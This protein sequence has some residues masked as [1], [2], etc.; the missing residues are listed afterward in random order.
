MYENSV[1]HFFVC[2]FTWGRQIVTSTSFYILRVEAIHPRQEHLIASLCMMV[3]ILRFG[4]ILKS[5]IP[6]YPK[7]TMNFKTMVHDLD[8][9]DLGYL[10]T[11][12]LACCFLCT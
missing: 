4:A 1:L 6:K 12:D 3:S 7:V 11:S 10:E 2:I 8:S 9:D 5:R